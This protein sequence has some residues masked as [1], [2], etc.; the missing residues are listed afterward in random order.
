[1]HYVTQCRNK[2]CLDGVDFDAE[3]LAGEVVVEHE[4]VRVTHLLAA[5][6]LM[7]TVTH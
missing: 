4:A 7:H 2:E 3:Q 5:G 1:M 6:L